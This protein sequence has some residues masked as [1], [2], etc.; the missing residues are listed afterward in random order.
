MN[1]TEK[2]QEDITELKEGQAKILTAL[3][4]L[5]GSDDGLIPKFKKHCEDDAKFRK[6]YYNFRNAV[7][8]VFIIAA[9]GGGI[10]IGVSEL[11]KVFATG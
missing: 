2:M 6:G 7:L 3:I 9:C 10:G 1:P 5:N 4:G 8:A 11:V